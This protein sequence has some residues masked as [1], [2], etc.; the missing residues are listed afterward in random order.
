MY[1]I[2]SKCKCMRHNLRL[3]YTNIATYTHCPYLLW[4]QHHSSYL[5]QIV[6][7]HVVYNQVLPREINFQ[8]LDALQQLLSLDQ[9]AGHLLGAVPLL[10]GRGHILG[11]RHR[12]LQADVLR[13]QVQGAGDVGCCRLQVL[14]LRRHV[15]AVWALTALTLCL[16]SQS[17]TLLQQRLSEIR[18]L[19]LHRDMWVARR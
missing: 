7:L 5:G 9:L 3:N 6:C 13:L 4:Q 11:G 12:G 15:G 10:V 19:R 1:L 2:I 18:Q 17:V 14:L 16:L 8:Q